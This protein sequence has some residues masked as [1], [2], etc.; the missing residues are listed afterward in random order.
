MAASKTFAA[1]TSQEHS[2]AVQDALPP[3]SLVY[4]DENPDVRRFLSEQAATGTD[5]VVLDDD[6]MPYK[7]VSEPDILNFLSSRPSGPAMQVVFIPSK[8][9]KPGDPFVSALVQMGVYDIVNPGKVADLD[10]S[11][12]AMAEHPTPFG[13]VSFWLVPAKG[14]GRKRGLSSLFPPRRRKSEPEGPRPAAAEAE[15]DRDRGDGEA[16]RP[17]E[18]KPGG[19]GPERAEDAFAPAWPEETDGRAAGR[20]RGPRAEDLRRKIEAARESGR[21]AE[22][23]REPAPAGEPAPDDRAPEPEGGAEEPAAPTEAVI[24]EDVYDEIVA[25]VRADF[26]KALER[27]LEQMESDTAARLARAGIDPDLAR[28]RHVMAVASAADDG[29]SASVAVESALWIAS[30]AQGEE[31]WCMLSSESVH[32]ALAAELGTGDGEL[33]SCR[34]V[35]FCGPGSDFPRRGRVVVD[36]GWIGA[37][38]PPA[39]PARVDVSVIAAPRDMWGYPAAS[40]SVGGK[41]AELSGWAW[42]CQPG[43]EDAVSALARKCGLPGAEI[44]SVPAP[45]GAAGEPADMGAVASGMLPKRLQA[46]ARDERP[47]ACGEAPEPPGRPAAQEAQAAPREHAAEEMRYGALLSPDGSQATDVVELGPDFDALLRDHVG[48]AHAKGATP[49]R[50]REALERKAEAKRR[51]AELRA[52]GGSPAAADAGRAGEEPPASPSPEHPSSPTGE[53]AGPAAAGGAWDSLLCRG[54]L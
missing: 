15:G 18:D 52:A 7:E 3:R 38:E 27:T 39:A 8:A 13:E 5:V 17:F 26:E 37:E 34:G 31:V 41:A 20:E 2:A 54:G 24:G 19:R 49:E 29:A 46:P 32:S 1:L 11:I 43:Q 45:R 16:E 36:L 21:G 22:P 9:R 47:P 12:A 48:W 51:K 50:A 33:F 4:I 23:P 35:R 14:E 30:R 25:R 10:A 44:A 42:C 53:E 28:S 6:G 40:R